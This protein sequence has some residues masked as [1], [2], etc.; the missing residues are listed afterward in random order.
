MR[1]HR[2]RGGILAYLGCAL[3]LGMAETELNVQKGEARGA[4]KTYLDLSP[5]FINHRRL[6]DVKTERK[7]TGRKGYEGEGLGWCGV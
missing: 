5:A 6:R 2:G 1:L 4:C 7:S 3:I